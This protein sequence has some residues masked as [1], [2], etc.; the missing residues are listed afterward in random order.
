M[1][2]THR[3]FPETFKREATDRAKPRWAP[4]SAGWSRAY[5]ATAWW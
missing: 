1:S 2:T 5:M 4:G 3:V